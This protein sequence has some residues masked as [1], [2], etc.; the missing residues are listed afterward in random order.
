MKKP[1]NIIMMLLFIISA[2][3]FAAGG[4]EAQTPGVTDDTILVGFTMPLSGPIGYI[5]AQAAR[6]TEAVFDKYNKQGGIYGRKLKLITYDSGLDPSQALANYR[7]LI[8]EDKVFCILFGFGTF[9]R[10]AYSFFEEHKVPWLFPM[11]P[12]NDMIFPPKKYLFSVFPTTATQVKVMAKW[13]IDQ[14]R[15]KRLAC[16]YGDSASGKTGLDGL[17]KAIAGSD[18]KLVDAEAIPNTAQSASVQVA[19]IAQAKP[20]LVMIIGMVHGPA[21]LSVKEIK[22]IGLDTDIMLAMPITGAAILRMLKGTDVEGM[23]GSWWGNIPYP[24]S[25]AT[26]TPK[27]KEMRELLTKYDPKLFNETSVGGG[28]E[29]A[30]SVELFIEAL[31]RAGKDLTREGLIKA[32]ESF[33]HYDK[34][35]GTYVTFSPTRREGV[36]GGIITQVRNGDWVPVSEW[37][38]VDVGE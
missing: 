20:D 29:H 24:N 10:P 18:V 37:I 11:A 2:S 22:K 30:L 31:R 15:Y 4:K 26:E 1:L 25:K 27:M 19:K 35:S 32:L 3:V 36:A 23:Y 5:G 17:K 7:K 9:V 13:T 28:V 38:D 12:P 33:K 6:A 14:K 34:G 16:I 21:A 8:L